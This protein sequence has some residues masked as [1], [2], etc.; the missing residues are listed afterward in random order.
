MDVTQDLGWMLYDVFDLSR[1]NKPGAGK[2]FISVFRAEIR[3]GVL[4]IPPYE[5]DLVRKPGERRAG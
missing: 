1:T 3:K 5:S 2:P 4:D